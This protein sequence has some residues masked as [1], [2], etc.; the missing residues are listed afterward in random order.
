MLEYTEFS[1]MCELSVTNK[2]Y[3]AVVCMHLKL[4][5]I[6]RSIIV[7]HVT[8]LHVLFTVY[9]FTNEDSMHLLFPSSQARGIV[10]T[11]KAT[12]TKIACI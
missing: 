6:D 5:L 7:L 10:S 1:E 2:F 12:A 11:T 3:A 4:S 8:I 9:A